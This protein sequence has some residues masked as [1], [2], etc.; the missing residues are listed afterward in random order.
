MM[1]FAPRF[2]RRTLM[3]KGSE[4]SGAK[5]FLV[6]LLIAILALPSMSLAASE[7]TNSMAGQWHGA[8][9]IPGAPL[10][11]ILDIKLQDGARVA[12]ADIPA[13]GVLGLGL[14]ASPV[15]DVVRCDF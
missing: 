15:L 12:T 13:Q 11:V 5:G 6:A 7:P 14:R 9:D 2:S 1:N 8:I 4:S 10:G 3:Y